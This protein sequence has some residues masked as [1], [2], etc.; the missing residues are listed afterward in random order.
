MLNLTDNPNK[1]DFDLFIYAY[2]K[3]CDSG[4]VSSIH[5]VHSQK[6]IFDW[7]I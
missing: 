1:Y 5:A 6:E 3:K 7:I 2:M 4:L